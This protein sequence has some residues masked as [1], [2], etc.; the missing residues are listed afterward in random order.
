MVE[1]FINDVSQGQKSIGT[2]AKTINRLHLGG[3]GGSDNRFNGSMKL[4]NLKVTLYD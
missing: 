4:D 3:D 1:L 2:I